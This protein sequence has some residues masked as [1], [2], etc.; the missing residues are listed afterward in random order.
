VL[1][2]G[3]AAELAIP[4]TA[5]F[6]FLGR[7]GYSTWVLPAVENTNLLFLGFG[8]EE[9][10]SGVFIGDVLRM[11]LA[12]VTGAG[13]FAVYSFDGF[14]NPIVHINSA[15]GISAADF[16][17][18]VAGGHT[19]LNWAFSAPGTYRI[20]F[21]ARGTLVTG[22]VEVVSDIAYYTFT[23]P[24]ALLPQ[25]LEPEPE[26]IFNIVNIGTLG[27]PSSFALDVNE[28]GQ[29]TGN[30]RYT[31]TNT[32]LHAYLWSEN[33][34]LDL[35]YLT[36]GVEF[37]RGYAINDSGFV[38]GESDNNISKAFLWDGTNMVNIGTL[39]GAS[40]V[41]H[42]I[43]SAGEIVGASSNGSAS[44]PYKRDLFGMMQDL[45]TLLGTTNSTGR[46]WGLNEAGAAVGLSRNAANTTSHAT[47]WMGGS[48][49]NLGSLAGGTNF[50]Q[51]YAINDSNVVVGSSVVGKVSPSSSTDLYHAFLW[52]DGA[53]VDLGAHPSNTNFIHSEAKDI[54]NAGEA[55]GYAAKF[56]GSPTSGGAAM[57]WKDGVAHDLN[58]LVP[59]GSG[60]VL[61]SA[62]GINDRGDIAGHGSYQGQTRA[63]LLHRA[64]RLSRGHTDIGLAFEDGGWDLHVHSGDLD[65][66]FEP[67]AALLTLPPL[68]QTTV[69]TN[70]SYA[71]L[72]APGSATWILPSTEN[73]KLLFL[74]FGAEEIESGVFVGNQVTMKLK[75]VDGPGTF[76][77]FSI[78]GF[79]VPVVHMNSGDGISTNDVKSIVTG[80]HED[81]AWG[82]TRPGYYRVTFEASGTLVAGNEFTSSGDVTYYFEVIGIETQ[83]AIARSGGSATIS[84]V[85][86]DGLTYQLESA[87]A[88][89]GPWADEGAAF[90]GTGRMKTITVPL[91]PG[92]QFFRM[93]A[94]N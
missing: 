93:K 85:T 43:N 90:L 11:E 53:M 33:S 2:V 69:P 73:P 23:V 59:A 66:E 37:S 29:V 89:T 63:F 8:A 42:D 94:D 92:A 36:N 20:G 4:D 39:G 81:F 77:V 65:Q 15:D 10:E 75:A 7:P 84:F 68:T 27:G 86:Q 76:S 57:L 21:R 5:A 46:A 64:T 48:I 28:A 40:A 44:R 56:F 82:F 25:P 24:E 32:R 30:S 12:S 60:W 61:Q 17:Q 58:H 35:G 41:A 74:G 52:S 78:D 14:G 22:N 79:G 54:N 70:A 50:S 83:L 19:D 49:S 47:L 13:D 87:P 26:L 16:F 18:V 80:S 51:A 72:G 55:V 31:T 45:G 67:G 91:S 9:V 3:E 62:E 71:F 38:V 34:L 88:V 6:S 1:C